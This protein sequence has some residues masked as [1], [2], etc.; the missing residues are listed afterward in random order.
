MSSPSFEWRPIAFLRDRQPDA[1]PAAFALIVLNQPLK[2][3]PVLDLLWQNAIVR[4]AADGGANRLLDLSKATQSQSQSQTTPYVGLILECRHP[5]AKDF[6]TNLEKPAQIV[7]MPDQISTDFGK[8]IR[9]IRSQHPNVD[10]VALG[11]L[12][13]RVDQ[14]LSQVHQLYLSQPGP[15][16]DEGK[17]YLVSGQSLTFLLKPGI[18]SIKVREGGEDV[19][20]KHVGI[21]PIGG[22]SYITTEGLEWDV[23]DW[24]TKFGGHMSTSNHVLPETKVVKIGTT[25]TVLFTIALAG[26]E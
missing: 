10:I 17:M 14:G 15:G 7:H 16:Y 1:E 13:G 20:G 3:T 12:G 23:V 18:H 24:E 5:A 6:Y 22:T 19:F 2:Q 26:I 9:W 8:S 21:I 4:V 11:G 25:E